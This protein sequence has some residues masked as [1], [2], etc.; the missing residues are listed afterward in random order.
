MKCLSV[1][2]WLLQYVSVSQA[3]VVTLQLIYLQRAFSNQFY[4]FR[5]RMYSSRK[6]QSWW[7]SFWQ[8]CAWIAPRPSPWDG[9][10][11]LW[12]CHTFPGTAHGLAQEPAAA[13]FLFPSRYRRAPKTWHWSSW[14][15]MEEGVLLWLN[16][17]YFSALFLLM[18][19]LVSLQVEAVLKCFCFAVCN[20]CVGVARRDGNKGLRNYPLFLN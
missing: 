2:C 4:T 3:K 12:W 20:Y 11:M 15:G 1:S 19:Y 8:H 10:A 7:S 6:N 18:I 5:V 13:L 17:I 14:I 9:E 16:L